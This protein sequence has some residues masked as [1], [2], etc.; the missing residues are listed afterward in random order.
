[1]KIAGSHKFQYPKFGFTALLH[2]E[3][4]NS[5]WLWIIPASSFPLPHKRDCYTTWNLLSD[6]FVRFPS[7]QLILFTELW[8]I[9]RITR[10]NFSE[11][12]CLIEIGL[13]LTYLTRFSSC[14]KPSPRQF[15]KY[16]HRKPSHKCYCKGQKVLTPHVP[17][18][19]L[20]CT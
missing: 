2:S 12:H 6:L 19:M 11:I 18:H 14:Y 3:F 8:L 4:Y 13:T 7:A 15:S 20:L 9:I 16:T 17:L 5:R 1:M 10:D